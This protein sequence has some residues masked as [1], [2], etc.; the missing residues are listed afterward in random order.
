MACSVE[1]LVPSVVGERRRHGF[2]REVKSAAGLGQVAFDQTQIFD[3][4]PHGDSRVLPAYIGAAA[5]AV[6][7]GVDILFDQALLVGVLRSHGAS[8]TQ[9]NAPNSPS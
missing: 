2:L 5:V 3:E 8:R 7:V 6:P 4:R 1:W 9:H